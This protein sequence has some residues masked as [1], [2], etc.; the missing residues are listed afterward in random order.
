MK[1]VHYAWLI[2]LLFVAACSNS[3]VEQKPAK[4]GLTIEPYTLSD[5]EQALISKTGTDG[6]EFLL[7]N[8]SI[9][10]SEDIVYE[11]VKFQNGK[12]EEVLM[13]SS[14]SMNK[15]FKSEYISFAYN[16]LLNQDT[17]EVVLG[18]PGGASSTD[19][20]QKMSS[21]TTG[22]ILDEKTELKKNKPVYVAGWAGTTSN[23]M[24]GLSSAESDGQLPLGVKEAELAYLYRV[25]LV[26]K[27]N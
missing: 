18:M 23:Q 9:K 8:G 4:S 17:M 3:E 1:V 10:D 27:Q 7:L 21:W 22:P 25:E 19:V 26:D 12:N 6:I 5:K 11:L 16:E 13:S 20:E 2:C 15:D 24:R 14:G